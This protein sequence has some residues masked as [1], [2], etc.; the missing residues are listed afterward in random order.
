[1]PIGM[2]V[3]ALYICRTSRGAEHVLARAQIIYVVALMY[4]ESISVQDCEAAVPCLEI[5]KLTPLLGG[6]NNT[7]FGTADV[8]CGGDAFGVIEQ[9]VSFPLFACFT[10]CVVLLSRCDINSFDGSSHS[11]MNARRNIQARNWIA[12]YWRLFGRH[13]RASGV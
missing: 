6:G 7:L 11:D 9:T 13:Y 5:A 12:G 3:V 10:Y 1:M 8:A 4:V 2:V